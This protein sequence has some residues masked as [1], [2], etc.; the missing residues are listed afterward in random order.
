MDRSLYPE[1]YCNY[2]WGKVFPSGDIASMGAQ[3]SGASLM[4]GVARMLANLA[5]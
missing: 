1:M 4:E 3:T 5:E 2:Y